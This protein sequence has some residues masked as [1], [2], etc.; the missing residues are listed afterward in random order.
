MSPCPC[1]H[2]LSISAYSSGVKLVLPI[3]FLLISIGSYGWCFPRPRAFNPAS[4]ARGPVIGASAPSTPVI[5]PVGMAPENPPVTPAP[6]PPVKEAVDCRGA[7]A[8][9]AGAAAV[10]VGIEASAVSRLTPGVRVSGESMAGAARSMLAAPVTPVVGIPVAAFAG[11]ISV[12]ALT[13]PNSVA[14]VGAD[15]VLPRYAFR[16]LSRAV[17]GALRP[18]FSPSLVPFKRDAAVSPSPPSS[19]AP[20]TVPA[21]SAFFIFLSSS[22]IFLSSSLICSLNSRAFSSIL[23]SVV[24]F[25]S[26]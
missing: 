8:E 13:G 5:P 22:L 23:L 9:S 18:I 19:I 26:S 10:A 14:V 12:V 24:V 2:L 3:K 25:W 6:T 4:T 21:F 16:N 20:L 11:P 7:S 17:S 1:P 15:P